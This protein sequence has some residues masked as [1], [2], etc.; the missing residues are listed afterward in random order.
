MK[1]KPDPQP[2][3]DREEALRERRET[4]II[5]PFA[6]SGRGS[7]CQEFFE[8]LPECLASYVSS[9][10]RKWKAIRSVTVMLVD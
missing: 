3:R 1:V 5:R 9:G 6:S 4:R 2:N 7:V 8:A 10:V